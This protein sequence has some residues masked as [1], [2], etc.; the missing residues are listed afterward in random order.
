M[1]DS[2]FEEMI[3]KRGPNEMRSLSIVLISIGISI[4]RGTILK[5]DGLKLKLIRYNFEIAMDKWGG[6]MVDY[7]VVKDGG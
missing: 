3:P 2:G 5:F 6:D 4:V 1:E 7:G